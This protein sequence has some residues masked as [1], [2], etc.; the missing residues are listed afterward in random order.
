M[1]LAITREGLAN[2]DTWKVLTK[3]KVSQSILQLAATNCVYIY[4]THFVW[5][6]ILDLIMCEN[7]II[8]SAVKTKPFYGFG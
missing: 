4:G 8:Q 1:L 3:I 2:A 6:A 7:P 5:R